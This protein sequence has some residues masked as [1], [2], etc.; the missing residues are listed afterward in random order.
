M[1]ALEQLNR[2]GQ[3][4]SGIFQLPFFP[5]SR[6]RQSRLWLCWY[7]FYPPFP[8]FSSAL[9]FP[10]IFFKTSSRGRKGK[11]HP[12]PL[13]PKGENPPKSIAVPLRGPCGGK[14]SYIPT[15][16]GPL[17]RHAKEATN[18]LLGE[19]PGGGEHQAKRNV[20]LPER[21]NRERRESSVGVREGMEKVI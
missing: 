13:Q 10:L 2:L 7:Q 20:C 9:P 12:L 18:N 11:F 21:K 8:F 14:S 4:Q 1:T 3:S 17:S 6:R 5:C 19:S 15:P 16:V